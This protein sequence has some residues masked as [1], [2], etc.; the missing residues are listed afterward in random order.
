MDEIIFLEL[1]QKGKSLEKSFKYEKKTNKQKDM[2]SHV[3]KIAHKLI[4]T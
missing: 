1:S 2:N 4:F 3:N